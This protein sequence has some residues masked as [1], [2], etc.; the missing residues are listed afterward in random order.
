MLKPKQSFFAD[1]SD[2][3][4]RNEIRSQFENRQQN[5]KMLFAKSGAQFISIETTSN[6]VKDLM[7]MFKER[8]VRR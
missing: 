8:G 1:T 7:Q 6:Y 2:K 3:K 4:L 5:S